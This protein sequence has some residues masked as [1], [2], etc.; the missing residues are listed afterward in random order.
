MLP[1]ASLNIDTISIVK[2]SKPPESFFE[3]SEVCK[4]QSKQ[5]VNELKRQDTVFKRDGKLRVCVF[6]LR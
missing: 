4:G 3:V 1:L 5:Q 6:G 2:E